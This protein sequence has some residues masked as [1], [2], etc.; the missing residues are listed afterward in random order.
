[1]S[2]PNTFTE[3]RSLSTRAPEGLDK[4]R[5]KEELQ[6]LRAELFDLQNV[7]YANGSHALLIILQ[8][9]DTSGK[10]GVVRHTLSSMD[11]LGVNVRSFK[12][13][14]E[15][16]L[17]HDFMWRIYPHFPERGK[18]KV[19]N[20]SHYEDVLVPRVTGA[21]GEEEC[22]RRYG[23]INAIEQH[24]IASGTLILKCFLHISKEEQKKRIEERLSI[25]R[26]RWKYDPADREAASLWEPYAVAN[27]AMLNA[28]TVVPWEIIPADQ[29]WYRN[30][31]FAELVRDALKSLNLSYPD[32][33]T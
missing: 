12:K 21:I 19:F 28:C 2:S 14:T 5:C 13:P 33:S 1:M 18:I 10:D 9:M 25:P 32:T 30:F 17:M 20:R 7:F 3:L 11:P 16:E 27:E 29:R 15:Q 4:S 6:R 26:K 23:V 8:G 22:R 24:L 31:R